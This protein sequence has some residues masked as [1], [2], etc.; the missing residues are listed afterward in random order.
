VKEMKKINVGVIGTGYWGKKHIYEYHLL[1]NVNVLGV[2]D[3]SPENL[4]FCKKEYNVPYITSDYR[5]LLENKKIDAVS[6][7]T[8]NEMHYQICR[9]AFGANKHVLVEKPISLSSKEAKD[10]VKIAKEKHLILTVGHIYRFN[11]ALHKM[12]EFIQKG[13]FQKIFM[14]KLQWTALHPPLKGRDIL[15]DLAPHSFDILNYLLDEWPKKI[16]CVAKTY[17]RKELE[18]SAYIIAEFG[19]NVLGH[20]EL[21]WLVPGKTREIF[22]IGSD[23]CA[24][25]NAVS[26]EVTIYESGYDYKLDI[27]RNNTIKD[28]LSYF[29]NC[30][31]SGE[32]A[33][34]SGEI[35]VKTIEM[36]EAAK[37]SMKEERTIGVECL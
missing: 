29:V 14:I 10:L 21:N 1:D 28:E 37:K 18:E 35:G 17:R 9:D 25:I 5:E 36:I 16:T 7:C 6:V 26:Q 31:V 2:S 33:I 24:R 32:K 8:P 20:I 3:I 30:I 12:R 23:R 4:E 13:F 22:I 11:N 19:N 34:N 27:P 15:F